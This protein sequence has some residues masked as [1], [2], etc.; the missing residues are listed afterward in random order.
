MSGLAGAV[1]LGMV[2]TYQL[3]IIIRAVHL[4]RTDGINPFVVGQSRTGMARW[5]EGLFP[6]V[7][8]LWT[9]DVVLSATDAPV[10]IFPWFME[11]PLFDW[12][13]AERVGLSL[14]G[15]AVLLFL[16]ALFAFGNSWRIGIDRENPGSLVTTG[17]FS[18]S[19]NPIFLSMDL[20]LLGTF[21]V[22]PSVVYLVFMC[23]LFVAI[24]FQILE[25][26]K[27]LRSE[28]GEVYDDYVKRTCR[29]LGW[30]KGAYIP[31]EEPTS[32]VS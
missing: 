8:M 21:L 24:H 31:V 19:R 11:R 14:V 20:I 10:R 4:W 17:I 9:I 12:V 25:E 15:I 2:A 3:A 22:I 18:V 32:I 16:A 13:V 26:E 1:F 23:T 27:F 29:Y 7:G 6:W 28:Y 30:K 5:L